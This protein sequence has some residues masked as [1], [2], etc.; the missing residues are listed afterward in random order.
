[1]AA[2]TLAIVAKLVTLRQSNQSWRRYQNHLVAENKW[3]AVRYGIDG[4]LI[5]FGKQEEVPFR[6]LATEMLAWVDDVVDELGVR[7][8]VEYVNV[9]LSEGS[10]A[11]RQLKTY[12]E[13]GDFKAVVD[14]IVDETLRFDR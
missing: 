7:R 13:T 14:Q 9:I 8:E 11:D 4:Q 2:L 1:M 6:S 5:D 12:R 10:S 3:R